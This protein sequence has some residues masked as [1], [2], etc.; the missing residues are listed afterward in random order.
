MPYYVF[1]EAKMLLHNQMW[2]RC[3][4]IYDLTRDGVTYTP[5]AKLRLR[6]FVV[7][8]KPLDKWIVQSFGNFGNFL[9]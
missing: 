8:R 3:K 1:I 9:T 2:F 7:Q 6:V 4:W 5:L